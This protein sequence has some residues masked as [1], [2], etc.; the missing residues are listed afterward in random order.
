MKVDVDY[1]FRDDLF[2]AKETGSTV[3]IEILVDFYAGVVYRYTTVTFKMDEDNVPHLQFSYDILEPK[4]FS[5]L[6][7]REDMRFAKLVG[8]ILN[9]LMLESADEEGV[10]ETRTDDNQ[11]PNKE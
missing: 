6:K 5:E 9:A 1:K 2:N 3:P 8:L 10:S 4:K 7:L 11:E